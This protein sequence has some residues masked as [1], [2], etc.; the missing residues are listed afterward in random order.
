MRAGRK[1]KEIPDFN[2]ISIQS[3]LQN[4]KK[5]NKVRKKITQTL[6]SCIEL[7]K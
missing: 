1:A 4:E 2:K 7:R 3:I 6:A 5:T